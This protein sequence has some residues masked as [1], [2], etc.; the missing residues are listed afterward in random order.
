[1][2][3]VTGVAAE[4]SASVD[5]AERIIALKEGWIALTPFF[6]IFSELRSSA[7]LFSCWRILICLLTLVAS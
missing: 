6:L 3:V 5:D 7:R 4:A 1:M 2:H